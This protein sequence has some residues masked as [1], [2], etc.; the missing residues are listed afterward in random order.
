MKNKAVDAPTKFEKIIM[1]AISSEITIASLNRVPGSKFPF[2]ET[3]ISN[4]E[5][6]HLSLFFIKFILS[7][8]QVHSACS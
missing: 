1:V 3:S 6:V 2:R 7:V 8:I 5:F 4:G